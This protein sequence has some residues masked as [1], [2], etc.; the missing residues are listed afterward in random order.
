VTHIRQ[1]ITHG[2]KLAGEKMVLYLFST[3]LNIIESALEEANIEP[4]L[5][6]YWSKICLQSRG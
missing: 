6:E 4:E 2:L 1:T 3:D 5:K